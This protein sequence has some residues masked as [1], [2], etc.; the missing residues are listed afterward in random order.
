MVELCPVWVVGSD[1]RG[2]KHGHP[3]LRMKPL[4]FSAVWL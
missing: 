2:W 4:V 3:H 1:R